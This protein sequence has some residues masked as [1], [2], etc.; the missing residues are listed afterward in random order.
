MGISRKD[1]DA[2]KSSNYDLWQREKNE[3]SPRLLKLPAN[4]SLTI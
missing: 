4:G 3:A 1:F 2:K